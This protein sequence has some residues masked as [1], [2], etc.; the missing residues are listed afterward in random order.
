MTLAHIQHC[1][2]S[3]TL[4]TMG[5]G[6][7]I[8]LLLF[9]PWRRRAMPRSARITRWT[10]PFAVTA[11]LAFSACGAEP[12]APT[13]RP[14]TTARLEIVQPGPNQILG[15]DFELDINLIGAK[16]V[17]ENVSGGTLKPDEGHIHV[18]LDGKL[19]NMT[20]GTSQE[21]K[22]VPPG[23]HTVQAEF[24]AADH[25]PFQNRVVAAVAFEVAPTGSA[26]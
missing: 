6:T 3:E 19:V 8:G 13:S 4:T 11:I 1:T 23:P 10:L 7:A 16:V 20:Y 14:S 26:S 22:D 2:T 17:P 25:A 21:M 12:P 24:V 9:R 18:S 5:I 15:P